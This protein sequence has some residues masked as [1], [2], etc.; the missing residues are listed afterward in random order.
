MRLLAWLLL[1]AACGNSKG[2]LRVVEEGP[3][4]PDTFRVAVLHLSSHNGSRYSREDADRVLATN[5]RRTAGLIREAALR[6]AKIIVTPEYGNSGVMIRGD[7]KAFASTELPAAPTPGPAWENDDDQV[8]EIIRDY[9]RL[10]HEVKAYVVT[11]AFERAHEEGKTRY[12][13]AMIAFDPEGRL[14]ARY[15]KIN[16]WLME[17]LVNS[18]GDETAS[19]D[20]P[21]GRFGMLVCFDALFPGTWGQ[22]TRDHKVDF[23]VTQSHWE[24]APLTGGMAMDLLAG[25]SG[26]TV[27]WS[28]QQR[29]GL[30][31]GAGVVRPWGLDTSFGIWGP[32]GVI[33]ANLPIPERLRERV[34]RLPGY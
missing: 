21:Y 32:P 19:F 9:A 33:V 14:I 3:G 5:Y 15:R 29:G 20:T 4:G 17:A 22:L 24:H 26:K 27:L 34:A 30:A 10:A 11:H 13:N 31:G 25:L 18:A 12:Y 6:G 1:L 16:R 2:M 8:H 23:L 28:N 7:A